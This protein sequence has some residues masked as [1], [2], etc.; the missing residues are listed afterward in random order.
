MKLFASTTFLN[1]SIYISIKSNG[2]E[3]IVLYFNQLN[4]CKIVNKFIFSYMYI[5]IN[6]LGE[7][8]IILV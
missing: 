6:E 1:I 5:F 4:I 2:V 8:Y 3:Y 7:I